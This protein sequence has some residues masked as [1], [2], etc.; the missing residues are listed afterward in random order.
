MYSTQTISSSEFHEVIQEVK[1]VKPSSEL[2]REKSNSTGKCDIDQRF[3]EH[4]KNMLLSRRQ[5]NYSAFFLV[6]PRSNAV[7]SESKPTVKRMCLRPRIDPLIIR[8]SNIDEFQS[9]FENFSK[10]EGHSCYESFNRKEIPASNN[11]L[12]CSVS[13]QNLSMLDNCC[14]KTPESNG[15]D[16]KTSPC[17][18]IENLGCSGSCRTDLLHQSKQRKCETIGQQIKET[19]MEDL[20]SKG[21]GF[22]H[23]NLTL[24]WFFEDVN[25]NNKSPGT[26]LSLKQI[27]PSLNILHDTTDSTIDWSYHIAGLGELN[28]KTIIPQKVASKEVLCTL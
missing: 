25:N 8:K 1:G 12:H 7:E 22:H 9:L 23:F 10:N 3:E 11:E 17:D 15:Y 26:Q 28:P 16:L 20:N 14:N 24:D 21:R 19:S 27:D 6:N 18:L 4:N 13:W 2:F 5:H